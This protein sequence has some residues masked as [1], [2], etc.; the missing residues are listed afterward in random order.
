MPDRENRGEL[1]GRET[2]GSWN[3]TLCAIPWSVTV[4]T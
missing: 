3:T 1:E 2:S 4:S